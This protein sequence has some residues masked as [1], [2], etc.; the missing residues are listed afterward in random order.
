MAPQGYFA[1]MQP[2]LI[3]SDHPTVLIQALG[4][5]RQ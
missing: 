5:A 3:Y 2:V 1:Y 4:I